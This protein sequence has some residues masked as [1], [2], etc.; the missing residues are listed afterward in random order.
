VEHGDQ[1]EHERPVRWL[2]NV[3][4]SFGGVASGFED[5]FKASIAEAA[6]G[7]VDVTA[8]ADGIHAAFEL[9]GHRRDEVEANAQ[10]I[11]RNALRAGAA[12]VRNPSPGP[13]GWTLSV[14]VEPALPRS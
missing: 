2:V 5:G 9:N 10:A 3:S 12:S 6:V 11:G 1:L 13:H 14:G 7:P 8:S 4:A